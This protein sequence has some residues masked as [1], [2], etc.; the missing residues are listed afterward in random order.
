LRLIAPRSRHS[1]GLT[2]AGGSAGFVPAPSSACQGGTRVQTSAPGRWGNWA[3]PVDNGAR[4]DDGPFWDDQDAVADDV[5]LALAVLE[6]AGVDQAHAGADAAVLVQDGPL[7]HG[8]I[9]HAQVWHAPPA[10][11]GAV[12]VGLE[13]L[14]AADHRVA[15]GYIPADPG[16]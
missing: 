7:D 15:Q 9:A 13:A 14:G 2:W 8:A 4:G 6:V 3:G 16:A 12:G 1:P 10:V 11:G 5:V